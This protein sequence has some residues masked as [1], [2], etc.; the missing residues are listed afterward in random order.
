MGDE[1][2]K[3]PVA[4]FD[5]KGKERRDLIEKATT[6]ANISLIGSGASSPQEAVSNSLKMVLEAIGLQEALLQQIMEEMVGLV[7]AIAANEQ[8]MYN[9][10]LQNQTILEAMIEKEV[11]T[12]EE[13]EKILQDTVMPRFKEEIEAATD[14]VEKK[15]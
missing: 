2:R 1:T 14:K 4:A 7:R 11:A 9:A 12:H 8:N 10:G 13:L 5:T 3:A 6:E 15:D